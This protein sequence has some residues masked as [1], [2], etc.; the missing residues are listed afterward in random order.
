MK[1]IKTYIL[2]FALG[3]SLFSCSNYTDGINE[4]PN[5]FT[6]APGKLIIGQA[7]L[8]V[9]KISSSNSSRYGGIFTDQFTGSERQYE[10]VNN[11]GVV[12][13]DF[14]DAWGDLYTFGAAQA[15][16]ANDSG[17]EDGDVLLVGVSQIMEA[18]LMGE[19][20][21]LWG[22][23]PYST[24]FDYT[25]NSDPTY[26]TQESVFAAVQSLLNDAIT[27]V[28]DA[29]VANV[30][31]QPVFV[32]NGAKW[33]EVAHSLKAR[34]YLVNKQYSEALL[35]ARQGIGSASG[36]LL[37]SHTDAT[38]A[39][40][41]YYQ[42]VIV[43]RSGYLTVIDSNLHK[44]LDGRRPRLLNTPGDAN[45]MAKYFTG[46]EL[47]TGDDGYFG[48]A[49]SSQIVSWVETKLIE[50]EAAQRTGGDALTPFNDVRDYLE[51]TYGGGFPHTSSSGDALLKEI[52][53]EKYISLPGSL[54]IFHD[55]R[56]TNNMIEVPIKGTGHSTIP[57]RF[58][59]PQVEINANDNFPGLIDLFEPTPINK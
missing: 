43:D 56:R 55:T 25:E 50:A 47:N 42:F 36:D 22:D 4:N 15:R 24:A 38:G 28:G 7:E 23:V 1:T 35:E 10:T 13:G 5:A 32:G 54:Q 58:Y 14:N 31:G 11:Y 2:L 12:A 9:V 51:A 40:N 52:L 8:T 26:D 48:S 27:N 46:D 44:L 16:L 45:R 17:V 29:T 39:R 49:A 19:A 59:Y 34:F 3:F 53:E 18:L 57:Q 20:A 37:S 33:A 21:S 41:M 30:Y 6:S